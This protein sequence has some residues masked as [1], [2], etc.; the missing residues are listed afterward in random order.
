MRIKSAGWF[1]RPKTGSFS[2][3][4]L[5]GRESPLNYRKGEV[6][7]NAWNLSWMWRSIMNLEKLHDIWEWPVIFFFLVGVVT[8]IFKITIAGFTPA[9]WFLLSLWFLIMIICFEV[10]LIREHLKTKDNHGD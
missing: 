8:A 6:C 4:Y 7:L 9:I 5:L 10:T 1:G 3:I 2:I